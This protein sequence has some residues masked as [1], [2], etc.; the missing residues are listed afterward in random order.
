MGLY[1]ISEL[2][3]AFHTPN[4][5]VSCSTSMRTLKRSLRPD[6]SLKSINI[7]TQHRL[8]NL[9]SRAASDERLKPTHISLYFA[10]CHAW[11]IN[12]FQQS[13]NVSRSKLMIL[14]RIQSKTTYHKTISELASMGYI[15]YAPSYHPIEGSKVSLLTGFRR[16]Q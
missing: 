10:L 12:R 15:R 4:S 16:L 3:G 14:S 6:W 11:I 5:V 8:S 1:R 7:E 2:R 9:I 13:Y